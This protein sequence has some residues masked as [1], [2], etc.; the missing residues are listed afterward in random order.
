MTE[1]RV[2]AKALFVVALVAIPSA[3]TAQPERAG[4][5]DSALIGRILLAE[6]RRDSTD[7]S[8]ALGM[9]HSDARI[10]ALAQR[11]SGRIRDPRFAA[12]DS[13]AP[14]PSPPHWPEPAWRLRYRALTQQRENCGALR[15]ALADSVWPVRL[16]ATALLTDHCASD[17]AIVATLR[18]WIDALPA[19]AEGRVPG[20]VPW[21]A[22]A[23]GI[24]ALARLRPDDARSSVGTLAAH[25]VW[26]MRMYVARAAAQLADT[27]RLRAMA[28]DVDDNVREI[29][30]EALGRLSGHADD[31]LY[32][33]ALSADGA[34]VVRAAAIALK[35]TPRSDA[36][37]A[38]SAGFERWVAGV[39]PPARDARI[40]LLDAAGRPATDDRPP[41]R[42]D[43]LPDRAV[44]LALGDTV[45]LRVTLAPRSGRRSFVVRLRG[46]VAP[47]MSARVLALARAGYYDNTGWH[48]VEHDFVVQ[49]LGPGGNEYVGHADYFRDELGTVPHA[50]GTIGMSTRGHDTGDA[51]W[52]VN[53]R[54]NLRL[55]RDYTV[56]A[57]VVLG[58]EDVD[59]IMEGDFVA[60]IEEIRR[61]DQ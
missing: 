19:Q 51:Q 18:S 21:H 20:D 10:R 22:A 3:A 2:A 32:I 46:D 4:R 16:R 55:G 37:G 7:A 43:V 61:P 45:L 30:I 26:Q 12:R 15:E 6:D 27:A 23:H 35:G 42:R 40:A 41:P 14:L 9:R 44:A 8:L 52:F 57:E 48:R 31:D 49:G 39:T 29:A 1:R 5:A 47:L 11:A 36:R 24:L 54:D 13:F 25:P 38:A 58:M 28:R 17:D 50:R 53:L 33:A 34:Q 60:R 56:F 59:G